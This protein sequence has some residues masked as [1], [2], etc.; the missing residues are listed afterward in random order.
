MAAKATSMP[1]LVRVLG[2]L[3]VAVGG[4]AAV[5]AAIDIMDRSWVLIGGAMLVMGGLFLLATKRDI[6][7]SKSGEPGVRMEDDLTRGRERS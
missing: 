1:A 7:R 2:V 3:L 4:A 6:P 5:W